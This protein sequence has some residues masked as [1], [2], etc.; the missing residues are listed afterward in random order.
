V[1]RPNLRPR[2]RWRRRALAASWTLAT[3]STLFTAGCEGSPGEQSG[4]GTEILLGEPDELTFATVEEME[5]ELETLDNEIRGLEEYL[6]ANPGWAPPGPADPDPLAILEAARSTREAAGSA[7]AAADT[8]RAANS[9]R[10]AAERIEHVKRL[11][12]VAEEMG[13]EVEPAA[14]SVPQ[15]N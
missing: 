9:L 12:G 13:I 3:C 15:G 2:A 1:S 7:L 14:E 8:A 5:I 10:M 11:L 6:A 4:S